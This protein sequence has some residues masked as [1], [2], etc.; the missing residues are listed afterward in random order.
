MEKTISVQEWVYLT[1]RKGILTLNLE[2]GTAMSTQELADKLDVSRTPVREALI[3]LQRDGLVTI[4]P[5]RETLVSR[6]DMDRVRQERFMRKNLELSALR[7]FIQTQNGAVLERQEQLIE[8]QRQACREGRY[9][10]LL[11]YD[12]EFHRAFFLEVSQ[13]LS[14]EVLEQMS[15]HYKR[16]RMLSLKDQ[17]IMSQVVLQHVEL[18]KAVR[19]WDLEAAEQI[20]DQHLQKLDQE[21][22]HLRQEFPD[23]FTKKEKS[24]PIFASHIHWVEDPVQV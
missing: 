8:G 13:P 12:D 23:F 18:M 22:V 10:A 20:L 24:E 16:V 5:Q 1:L 4:M 17:D 7:T 19:A 3:R 15:T 9:S 21:E 14:W 6:I 11:E 2:P